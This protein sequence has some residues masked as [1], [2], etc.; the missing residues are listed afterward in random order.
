[1][2]RTVNPVGTH[3]AVGVATSP[4]GSLAQ[5]Y[6]PPVRGPVLVATDGRS[7]SLP[8]LRAA[9]AIA[10]RLGTTVD[11]VGVLEP[12]PSY[13]AAPETP[14]LPPDIEE[15]R[16]ASI[17]SAIGQR[18]AALGDGAER[19][20]VSIVRGEPGRTVAAIA[21]E[22]DSSVIV[23]GA[24]RHE[25]RDRLFGGERALRVIRAADRPVVAV[26]GEFASL[27][28]S[29]VVGIDFS[30]A[31]VRAARAALLM[32]GEEGQLVLVYV[33]PVIEL[34]TVPPTTVL[35]DSSFEALVSRWRAEEASNT[36]Q[37]FERLR[38]ELRPYVQRGVTVE[39]RT[40]TGD[41]PDELLAVAVDVGADML[42]VGTHGPGM[43][44]RF[45]LG[46]VATD[47][48][49]D[50][51][52]TVL[53]APAP[54]PA[55]SARLSLRLH[56]TTELKKADDWEPALEGFSKRNVGRPVRLEVD[57]PEVGAQTQEQGYALLGVSY[58]HHDRRV[59][60]MV[61]DATDRV[62]HLTRTI[63]HVDDVGF[64]ATPTG[65]ERALRVASGR[66]QTL[67]TF[68]D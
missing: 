45:F 20:P 51:G 46:S 57:D 60:I 29:A 62:R 66:G 24:G 30:P 14:I 67:L 27:P 32:L 61:G 15:M 19:W 12:V 43:L 65:G 7:A 36:A 34:P 1:M 53:V 6:D 5:S 13:M 49:R 21:R 40:R 22:R 35:R 2:P 3:Q 48:L 8:T 18:L 41:P 54:S 68:M 9:K 63:T 11:V 50:A 55:E 37:R 58:D 4:T 33:A 23:V 64:Y 17:L 16:R 59:E 28:K 44:E 42:A 38:E 25:R 47:M 52:R 26:R 31:S 10:D 39:T 56:G